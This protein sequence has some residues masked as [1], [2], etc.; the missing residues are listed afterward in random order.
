MGKEMRGEVIIRKIR[1]H[2]TKNGRPDW[3][4]DNLQY[5]TL[6]GSHAY[7]TNR[8][9][10]DWDVYGFTVPPREMLLPFD[11]VKEY[12]YID[13]YDTLP[14]ARFEQAQGKIA[15]GPPNEHIEYQI[16]SISKYFQLV[17]Q[18]NPNMIDSLFTRDQCVLFITETGKLVRDNRKLFLHKGCWHRFRGY[19]HSQL[20]KA[21]NP[22]D[23]K[24]N[25]FRIGLI[26]KYGYD[27]K[28][29]VHL[30]RLLD[31]VEQLLRTG[32]VD[33]MRNREQHKQVLNGFYT[34]EEVE[35]FF[36]E[37]ERQLHEAYENSTLPYGPPSG[38]IRDLLM[39]C[40]ERAL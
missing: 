7:G 28:F 8:T 1:E 12:C 5:L 16:Y 20:R 35:Q 37:R 27:T 17:E 15:D 21:K 4:V 19:A 33:L 29:A 2:S 9:D 32:D 26:K 31:E 25:E 39:I 22:P 6:M 18:N 36:K 14:K 3:I 24:T 38:A 30:Y 40:I 23:N 10:S 13:G 34:Y 11:G